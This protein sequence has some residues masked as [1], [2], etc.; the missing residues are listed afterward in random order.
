MSNKRIKNKHIKRAAPTY[1]PGSGLM[2]V[3][4][5]QQQGILGQTFYGSS[6]KNMPVAQTNTFT[7]GI[8]LAP[9]SVVTPQGK[10]YQYRF[11]I[12]YNTFAVDRSLGDSEKPSFE[13]LRRLAKMY[14]GITLC[15]RYWSDMVPRMTLDIRLKKVFADAGA[16]T[17]QYQKA[18]NF[19]RDFWE[20]PDG[21]DDIHTWLRKALREQTQIDELYLYKNRTRGGKLLGLWIVAGDQMKPLLDDWGMIPDPPGYA[22]QQYPWG[23]PGMQYT[24]DMMIHYQESPAADSPF[25]FSRVE[26]IILEV[27]Q[28]LRKKKKDLS[29]FTEGNIPQSFMEVPDSLN[30]TPDQIDAYEQSWNALLAGS[31]QQQIRMKFLQP[32]MK[33]IP[34]EQYAMLSDFDLFLFRV[35]CGDYGVPITEFSFTDTSNRSTGES[36]EDVVYR[37]TI[38]PN[39][40]TYGRII[41]Q[42]MAEDFPEELHGEMFEAVFGGYEEIEDEQKKAISITTYTNAGVLGISDAAKLAGLPIDPDAA[43]V[44]RL[45]MT[46]TGP[47]FLDDIASPEMRQAQQQATMAGYQLAANPPEPDEGDD[48]DEETPPAKKQPPAK[49]PAAKKPPANKATLNRVTE[50][51]AD[52]I[53]AL[54]AHEEVEAG[55]EAADQPVYISRQGTCHCDVCTGRNG[56]PA[57]AVLPP[58]HDGCDCTVEPIGDF[59]VERTR[60]ETEAAASAGE[61]TDGHHRRAAGALDPRTAAAGP[62]SAGAE[63]LHPATPARDDGNPK[64][65]A[66]SGSPN[67]GSPLLS[68]SAWKARW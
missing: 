8:P 12:A 52:Y 35:T 3:P 39:A 40:S 59:H 20:K 44:G 66:A 48:Q 55:A 64:A 11:P 23:I 43:P 45:I 16:E 65:L 62:A 18:I 56:Q 68:K 31:A 50:A 63:R 42:S 7:P 2:Y 38:G 30:W 27:N 51:L 4:A 6:L 1:P 5:G 34:A 21:K 61:G 60:T 28:A 58:Y 37:R 47:V 14:S 49:K 9:Q 54:L 67:G 24:R 10:P 57:Q 36:Q 46:K 26:R 53:G 29:N 25:G 32:G 41:T 19:F 33:Y 13:T 22:Y 17:K 15:E